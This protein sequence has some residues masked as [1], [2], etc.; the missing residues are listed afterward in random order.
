MMYK[1]AFNKYT[2]LIEAINTADDDGQRRL[3]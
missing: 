2:E 1:A 3:T